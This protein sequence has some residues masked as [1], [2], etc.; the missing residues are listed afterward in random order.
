M[1]PLQLLTS[2]VPLAAL[3]RMTTFAQL[4]AME[5]IMATPKATLIEPE[6]PAAP[7]GSKHWLQS[8]EQSLPTSQIPPAEEE[9]ASK[10]HPY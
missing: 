3:M 9:K 7:S 10:K 8:S 5:D 2:N 6:T 4:Q 1:Y